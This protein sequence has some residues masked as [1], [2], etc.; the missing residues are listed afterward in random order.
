MVTWSR[1]LFP[2]RGRSHRS[3]RSR[4]QRA[5]PVRHGGVRPAQETLADIQPERVRSLQLSA[6]RD[7]IRAEALQHLSGGNLWLLAVCDTVQRKP[8]LVF[9]KRFGVQPPERYR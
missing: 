9:N 5:H 6:T 4:S 3:C 7:N 8:Y 1:V 2:V